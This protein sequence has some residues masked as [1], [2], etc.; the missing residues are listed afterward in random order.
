MHTPK[1]NATS[2]RKQ[3]SKYQLRL[4]MT[5]ICNC[6][7][8]RHLKYKTYRENSTYTHTSTRMLYREKSFLNIT[9][10]GSQQHSTELPCTKAAC[11][12]QPLKL[13]PKW[14][15]DGVPLLEHRHTASQ[16]THPHLTG[17][18]TYSHTRDAGSTR[19]LTRN[20]PQQ[21]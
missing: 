3:L 9:Q 1:T 17:T 4:D 11:R 15:T 18:A 6:R 12:S 14:C 13:F 19:Q 20:R 7:P 8:N 5:R 2:P 16:R 21:R 10:P